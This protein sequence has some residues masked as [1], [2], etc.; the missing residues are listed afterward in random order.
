M[1]HRRDLAVLHT[2]ERHAHVLAFQ[3]SADGLGVFV[4]RDAEELDRFSLEP[5][6]AGQASIDGI[7]PTQGPHQVAQKLRKIVLPLN[8][9]KETGWSSRSRTVQSN[10]A[11]WLMPEF[12]SRAGRFGPK[13]VRYANQNDKKP[14]GR[15]EQDPGRLAAGL[16]MLSQ[17]P[18]GPPGQN[19]KSESELVESSV[20]SSLSARSE[21]SNSRI[22]DVL[23]D[24]GFPTQSSP[25][26]SATGA[27]RFS[28]GA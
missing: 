25:R 17:R 24:F 7:S 21:S 6:V 23:R 19:S 5:R 10:S 11:G 3:E 1:E 4:G 15:V 14:E 9:E 26:V 22:P 2:Q 20:L 12:S 18:S 13:N 27:S 8:L 28:T 16:R